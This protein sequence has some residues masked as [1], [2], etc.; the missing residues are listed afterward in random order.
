MSIEIELNSRPLDNSPDNSTLT[1]F[2]IIC[3][4]LRY[5]LG[6]ARSMSFIKLAYIFDKTINLEEN[7]FSSKVTLSAWNIDKDFKKSLILA[8]ANGFLEFNSAN[9]ARVKISISDAG[10]EYLT[11]IEKNQ[12][13]TKYLKYLKDVKIPEN[14]FNKI[15]IRI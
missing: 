13:F 12:V 15:T 6:S 2:A 8:E 3:G 5:C 11:S 7:A 1:H 4:A 14:R 9:K 10:N